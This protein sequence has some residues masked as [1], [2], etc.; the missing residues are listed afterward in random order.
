MTPICP[1]KKPNNEK[2]DLEKGDT[3]LIPLLPTP[4][5][6]RKR[7]LS[8]NPTPINS[9][10]IRRRGILGLRKRAKNL[11]QTNERGGEGPHHGGL[12]NDIGRNKK[13]KSIYAQR[14]TKNRS[15][16][17]RRRAAPRKKNKDSIMT[18]APQ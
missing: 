18:F 9:Q 10:Q 11:K 12:G 14:D 15:K 2:E 8:P 6:K 16:S 4:P 7:S 1:F 17:S 3:S 13:S 5:K